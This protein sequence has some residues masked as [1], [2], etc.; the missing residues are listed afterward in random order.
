MKDQTK[1]QALLDSNSEV[2]VMTL[3]YAAKLDLKVQLTN[4]GAQKIDG[5]NFYIFGIVLASF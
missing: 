2:N 1:I 3:A 5:S 4:I